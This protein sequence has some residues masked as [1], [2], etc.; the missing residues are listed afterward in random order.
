MYRLECYTATWCSPCRAIKPTLQELQAEYSDVIELE[1]IDTDQHPERAAHAEVTTLPHIVIRD[2]YDDELVSSVPG[3]STT[4]MAYVGDPN[5][6]ANWL[7]D[8][9]TGAGFPFQAYTLP[10]AEVIADDDTDSSWLWWVL[11]ALAAKAAF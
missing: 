1:W 9:I 7:I 8:T 4:Y 11:A 5:G 10:P 2:A 6:L 3:S